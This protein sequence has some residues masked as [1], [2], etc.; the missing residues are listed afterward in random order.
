MWPVKAIKT[1]EAGGGWYKCRVIYYGK[2]VANVQL[3]KLMGN[4]SEISEETFLLPA[5]IALELFKKTL[6]ETQSLQGSA[7]LEEVGW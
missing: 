4:P 6:D 1:I 5:N 3:V 2:E 7:K